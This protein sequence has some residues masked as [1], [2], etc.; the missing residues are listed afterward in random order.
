M[1]GG[2]VCRMKISIPG[3]IPGRTC[4]ETWKIALA[5]LQHRWLEK[6]Q[7]TSFFFF[8]YLGVNRETCL[9]FKRFVGQ[10]ILLGHD[11]FGK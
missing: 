10:V 5:M 7:E 3:E 9:D 8:K 4:T 6:R 11:K 2:Y 1:D